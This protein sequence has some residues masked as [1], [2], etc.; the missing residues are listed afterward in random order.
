MHG[1]MNSGRR[2]DFGSPIDTSHPQRLRNTRP[3]NDD[4]DD[5]MSRAIEESRD[6]PMKTSVN[7]ELR[8][9]KPTRI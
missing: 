2:N 9:E 7:G 8:Q 6:K 4:N 5:E 1:R 3:R